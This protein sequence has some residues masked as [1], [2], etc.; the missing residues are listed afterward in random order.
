M[1]SVYT[2]HSWSRSCRISTKNST[3]PVILF[4]PK[5]VRILKR[6]LTGRRTDSPLFSPAEAEAR[7]RAVLHEARATPMSC[8]NRP[9][10]NRAARPK[11]TPGDHYTV[12]SY[13]RAI[14]RA[15]DVVDRVKREEYEATSG[16]VAPPDMRFVPRWH[17]HQLRHTYAT[18]VR[19]RYGLEAAQILLGHSSALVTDAVY[20]ER[21]MAKAQ[22]IAEKIG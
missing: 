2:H 1:V 4:G 16:E 7:R 12:D 11:R 9:G 5:A 15:C 6:Y 8:G 17:P 20:A 10:T 13:R 21:D 3:Y 14:Q 19:A 22:M 18:R